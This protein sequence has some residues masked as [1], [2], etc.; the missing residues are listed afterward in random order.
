M[1]HNELLYHVTLVPAQ[2]NPL[3]Q[4]E[5]FPEIWDCAGKII[6]IQVPDH[7]EMERGNIGGHRVFCPPSCSQS[8]PVILF[9][10]V[11]MHAIDQS[12]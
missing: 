6:Q 10:T 7:S 8:L 3:T 9:S 5:H 2:V 4:G 1:I 12:T 11:N